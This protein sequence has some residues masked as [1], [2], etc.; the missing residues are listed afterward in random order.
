LSAPGFVETNIGASIVHEAAWG[1]ER[2]ASFLA[3]GG[4]RAQPDEVATL[5]SWLASAEASNVNGAVVSVD[6]GWR[7]P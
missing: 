4:R 1:R 7:T 6:G 2:M 5:L 3:M